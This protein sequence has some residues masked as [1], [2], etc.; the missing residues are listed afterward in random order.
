MLPV[1]EFSQ[2]I[3]NQDWHRESSSSIVQD[4]G[5]AHQPVTSSVT[6]AHNG[7]QT[8]DLNYRHKIAN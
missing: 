3:Y 7:T 8:A 5:F 1:K 4:T 2:M 6:D